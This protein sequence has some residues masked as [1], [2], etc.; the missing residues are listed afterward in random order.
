GEWNQIEI[1]VRGERLRFAAN[2]K[3]VFDFTDKPELL[4]TSPVG[5]QLHSNDQPQEYFFR[6]LLL[7]DNPGDELVT[8]PRP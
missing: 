2:G 6:S 1:L 4:K 8:V 7:S 5:L 3:L